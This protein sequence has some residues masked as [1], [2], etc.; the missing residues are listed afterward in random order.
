MMQQ[1]VDIAVRVEG[2]ARY[3]GH[4]FPTRSTDRYEDEPRAVIGFRF[5]GAPHG[6]VEFD[7]TWLVSLPSDENGVAEVM[8]LRHVCAEINETQPGERVIFTAD[9]VR[10]ETVTTLLPS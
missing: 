4:S 2:I 7:R 10:R 3:L 5:I 9:E 6:N 1:N 8:H